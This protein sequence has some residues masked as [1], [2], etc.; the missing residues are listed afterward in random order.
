MTKP[1]GIFTEPKIVCDIIVPVKRL[2]RFLELLYLHD[3][4][5]EFIGPRTHNG[6]G[7]FGI[8]GRSG[9]NIRAHRMAHILWKSDVA[10]GFQIL[11]TCHNRACCN[12]EHLYIGTAKD[13]TRDMMLAGRGGGGGVQQITPELVAQMRILNAQG[14][15]NVK[16]GKLLGFS[17][18]TVRVYLNGTY[19]V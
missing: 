9:I 8:G 7:S 6:Y 14:Y 17:H 3:T 5:W 18:E 16:I 13:N 15:S 10:P 1:W 11:H 12:P 4:C 2:N 19:N